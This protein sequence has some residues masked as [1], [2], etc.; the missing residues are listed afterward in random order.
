MSDRMRVG[1]GVGVGVDR[2]TFLGVAGVACGALAAAAWLPAGLAAALPRTPAAA[3]VSAALA[4]WTIDDQWG[5]WPRYAE[6][7]GYASPHMAQAMPRDG[8]DALFA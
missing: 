4:D 3:A 6:P 2:R 5:V 7:I 8:A 1:V